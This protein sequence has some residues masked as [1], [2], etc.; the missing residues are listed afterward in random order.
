MSIG[1]VLT[2]TTPSCILIE[3]ALDG[4]VIIVGHHTG[5]SSLRVCCLECHFTT[6]DEW[7]S[8]LLLPVGEVASLTFRAMTTAY[9]VVL[10]DLCLVVDWLH[11][12]LLLR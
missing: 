3:L 4:L 6:A 10:A 8:E 11:E 9:L 7:S 5:S 12:V 1:A 2:E